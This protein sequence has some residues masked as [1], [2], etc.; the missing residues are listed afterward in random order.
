MARTYFQIEYW[1]NTSVSG[2]TGFTPVEL[3]FND[4]RPDTFS[5]INIKQD[6]GATT[7]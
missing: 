3:M 2:S 5:K 6:K 1:L 4:I 7:K